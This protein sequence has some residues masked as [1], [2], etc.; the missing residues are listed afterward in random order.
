MK[1]NR[2]VEELQAIRSAASTKAAATRKA[3]KVVAE[4]RRIARNAYSQTWKSLHAE[5]VKGWNRA[6]YANQKAA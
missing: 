5:K 4:A 6:W 3:M 1:T 2:S